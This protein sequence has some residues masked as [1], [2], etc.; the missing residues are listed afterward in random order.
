MKQSALTLCIAA[1]LGMTSLPVLAHDAGDWLVRGRI[2]NINPSDDNDGVTKRGGALSNFG[3]ADGLVSGT[4]VGVEDAWTLDIDIT[5][6]IT[7]NWG[8]ELL[9]DLS[10][11]HDI[12]AKGS[13][14]PALNTVTEGAVPAVP[15]GATLIETRVLPPALLLQY[16]FM[17]HEQIQP[18]VGLGLNYTMFFNEDATDAAKASLIGVTDLELENSFGIA[19]QIGADFMMDNG[20]F[21]NID[22]KYIDINTTAKFNSGALGYSEAEVDIDPWVIGIGVGR[23][24]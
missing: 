9:L 23:S 6:M 11:Q 16:H 17:P 1:S 15:N 22:L 18:Y 8:V 13:T 19:A 3:V 5:Y 7:D 4:E 21:A 24:F 20:W 2:I 10:S 14:Y 12:V